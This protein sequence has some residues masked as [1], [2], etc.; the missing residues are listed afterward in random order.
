MHSLCYRY[1]RLIKYVT[2]LK[3]IECYD[4]MMTSFFIGCGRGRAFRMFGWIITRFKATLAYDRRVGLASFSGVWIASTVLAMLAAYGSPLGISTGWELFL[5]SLINSALLGLVSLM[6]AGLLSLAMVPIPR[7]L[8]SGAVYTAVLSYT[9]L[10]Y[11]K[12]GKLMSILITTSY[13]LLAIL[14]GLLLA[15]IAH[16]KYSR[17]AK[18]YSSIVA[19]LIFSGLLLLFQ[20][21]GSPIQY[22]TETNSIERL[23]EPDPSQAGSYAYHYFT[24]GSGQDHHRRE[25]GSEVE[26]TT[27]SVDASSMTSPWKWE[28]ELFWGFNESEL[29]LNGRVWLPA[30]QGEFPLVLIVHGNAT[31]EYFSDDGYGYLGELLASRGIIAVSVDEN[32]LN[33]SQWSGVPKNDMLV[34]A[35]ILLQHLQQIKQF[36]EEVDNPFFAQVD[37]DNVGLV[38]HSRGG[39]AIVMAANYDSW[40]KD[41][42]S[43]QSMPPFQIKALAALAATDNKVKVDEPGSYQL[44]DVYYLTIQG[45][46]DADVSNFYGARQFNRTAY[47]TGSD[48]FKTSLYIAGANHSHFNTD[49]GTLDLRVPGGLFLTGVNRMSKLDQQAIAQVYL[50]AFFETSL[51]GNDHYRPLFQD[52]RY[53]EHWLPQTRYFSRFEDGHFQVITRFDGP[54]DSPDQLGRHRALSEGLQLAIEPAKHRRGTN[55]GTKGL[56]IEWETAGSYTLELSNEIPGQAEQLIF[57]MTD[58]GHEL[59]GEQK[60][61]SL[62]QIELELEQ[63]NGHTVRFSLAKLFPLYPSIETTFTW[64][65]A[66]EQ[67]MKNKAYENA[68]EATF[69][70]FHIPL[71][72]LRDSVVG[73]DKITFHFADGPGKVMLDDIGWSYEK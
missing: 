17:Q 32:F 24:Y 61:D 35:W 43:L 73:Y 9:M 68:V 70:T 45:A 10:H 60:N 42:E 37:W 30:G 28:R 21:S 46:M 38:G 64:L 13:V 34:R 15:V 5:A 18:T 7:F 11:A 57:S 58:L 27:E 36:S 65:P 54:S 71:A 56:Q 12:L 59:A 72:P 20:L 53:G 44:N 41:D 2:D 49:W 25:F 14:L 23:N 52:Y 47:P 69:Q 16:R 31:M 48:R 6:L 3:R 8:M 55:I 4:I 40:F 50:S 33:Y 26:L 29:P 62:A 66:L 67:R 63:T 22:T 1:V 39:Q 19:I 51:L